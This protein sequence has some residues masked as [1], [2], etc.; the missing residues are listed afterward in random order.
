MVVIRQ[1]D[2]NDKDLQEI[3]PKDKTN[4]LVFAAFEKDLPVGWITTYIYPAIKEGLL[5]SLEVAPGHQGKG[6]GLKLM[7]HLIDH[8]KGL[9]FRLLNFQF[10]DCPK[11]ESILKKTGWEPS[12]LLTRRYFLHHT[13]FTPDWFLSPSQKLPPG[14]AL[15]LW[16][17]A[18]P[19]ELELA[20]TWLK[21]NLEMDQYSPFDPAHPFDP[22]T[23][24]GLTYKGKLAGWMINHRLNPKLLRY[25]AFYV[26]PDVRGIGPS[27]L[28]L[29]DSI[30]RHLADNLEMEGMMEINFKYS[31]PQW[32]RFIE[33]RL[34]PYARR[35]E[36][37]RYAYHLLK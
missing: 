27:V 5:T 1:V 8:L 35:T 23:S 17:N 26:V 6:I 24:L 12:T 22:A 10:L 9:E 16:K 37:M 30:K 36:D 28:M 19:Q 7:Q 29:K 4:A 11:L 32:I 14:F 33:K 25:T 3:L 31:P 2:L 13:T 21:N 20:K 18:R 15:F 34:A